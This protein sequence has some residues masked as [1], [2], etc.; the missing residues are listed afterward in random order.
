MTESP[1]KSLSIFFPCYNDKGTIGTLVLEAQRVAKTL[2]DNFEV[3]VIEDGSKDG[4]R[5]LLMDLK[6]RNEIPEFKLV[7]H[8]KNRGYGAVL[9]TGFKTVSK[10]LVFY[11]DGDGQYDIRELPRLWEKMTNDV[12]VVNGFK[13]KRH[14]P[15]HRIIIGSIYQYVMKFAFGLAIKDVDCDF[16]LIRRKV[17]DFVELTSTTGTVTIELVKRIQQAGFRFTEVGVAH[18]FRTYGTSQFFNFRRVFKTLW[19]LIFLWGDL[20]LLHTLSSPSVSIILRKVLEG[21]FRKQKKVISK[22]FAY[23]GNETVLDIGCGTGEFSPLLRDEGY[24]GLDIT[25]ANIAYASRHYPKKKFVVGDARKFS[26]GD[27]S[28][29][30][31]LV[32]GVLH[33]ISDEDCLEVFGEIRRVLKNG[34][35]LVIMEDTVYKSMVSKLLRALDRGNHIRTFSAWKELLSGVFNVQDAF[36]FRTGVGCPYSAFIIKN[37][38]K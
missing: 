1:K 15:F 17:F 21:N 25:E 36:S 38:K 12:D 11:T 9:Q 2:T 28:F 29:D 24:T 3:I 6:L 35:K 20:V 22:Y 33:H 14:D 7:L 10:D 26:F 4:S 37:E 23:Q 34:G 32:I 19:K 31:V 16:R 8:E 13:I 5:E 18:H 30:G 27:N